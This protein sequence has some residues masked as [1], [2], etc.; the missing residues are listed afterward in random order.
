MNRALPC[1][2]AVMAIFFLVPT[3]LAA[4]TG[5]GATAPT[6]TGALLQ[7]TFTRLH[8]DLL[9]YQFTEKTQLQ[10]DATAKAET[11][12]IEDLWR[13]RKAEA[14]E[15]CRE[16][17]DVTIT[18]RRFQTLARCF[19][20][21]LALDKSYYDRR[22]ES[23]SDDVSLSEKAR[24]RLESK[25]ED[26]V[27]AQATLMDGVDGGIYGTQEQLLDAKHKLLELYLRPLWATD[28]QARADRALG[29]LA[30]LTDDLEMLARQQSDSTRTGVL[31][32]AAECL[33]RGADDLLSVMDENDYKKTKDLYSQALTTLRS[34]NP[35]L[36]DAAGQTGTTAAE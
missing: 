7:D 22:L 8:R 35:A 11:K 27:D 19:R 16:Q 29:W 21:D 1:S 5:S 13:K 17:L 2:I 31:Y 9:L 26:L 14:R 20:D 12:R 10:G 24:I 33:A 36:R 25:L 6:D 3:A 15:R 32:T 23:I 18:S 30:I 28:T 34:C 4:E